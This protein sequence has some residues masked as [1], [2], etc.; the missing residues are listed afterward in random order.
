M[1]ATRLAEHLLPHLVPKGIP[2]EV[3]RPFE[4]DLF[5]SGVYPDVATLVDHGVRETGLG[6]RGEVREGDKGGRAYPLADAAVALEDRVG[7]SLIQETL[8]FDGRL[9]GPAAAAPVVFHAA[10]AVGAVRAGGDAW[11]G[12]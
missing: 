10:A 4:R 2:S 3:V 1:H 8:E 5:F 7:V 11:L 9:D 12:A 6:R